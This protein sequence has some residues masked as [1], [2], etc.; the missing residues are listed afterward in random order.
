MSDNPASK[1][2]PTR[3]CRTCGHVLDR[4][5]TRVYGKKGTACEA[6]LGHG[7]VCPCREWNP[8]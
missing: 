5:R 8:G 6:P 2:R 4:H 7:A 1:P 3:Y